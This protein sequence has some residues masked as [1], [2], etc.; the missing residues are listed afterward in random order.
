MKKIV[1]RLYVVGE[2]SRSIRAINT[3]REICSEELN[4]EADLEIIDML[5]NPFLAE[6]DGIIATPTL[7]KALPRPQ[8]RVI[9][10]LS[11]KE[12]LLIGLDLIDFEP[13]PGAETGK[14]RLRS[15]ISVKRTHHDPAPGRGARSGE[16][17][18]TD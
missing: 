17:F 1:F 9:G 8:K 11:D 18:L 12:N 4:G 15:Q 5:K 6:N 14:Q 7:V 2:T 3:M 10:D 13:P 16:A